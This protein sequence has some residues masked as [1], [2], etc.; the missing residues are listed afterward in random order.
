MHSHQ[1]LHLSAQLVLSTL[2]CSASQ[3]LHLLKTG[4]TVSTC[5]VHSG[6]CG[7]AQD[8]ASGRCYGNVYVSVV[9]VQDTPTAAPSVLLVV[10]VWYTAFKPKDFQNVILLGHA[11]SNE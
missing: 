6:R 4:I 11:R 2:L 3:S 8:L 10:A 5:L 7:T 1:S 9:T